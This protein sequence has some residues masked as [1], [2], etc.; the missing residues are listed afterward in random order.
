LFAS[1]S[2]QPL[3]S[4]PKDYFDAAAGTASVAIAVF[5]ATKFPKKGTVFLNPGT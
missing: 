3:G 4:V 2:I 5:K 1:Q